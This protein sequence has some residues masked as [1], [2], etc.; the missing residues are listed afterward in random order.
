MVLKGFRS[1]FSHMIHRHF[2]VFFHQGT[3]PRLYPR[4][5]P[6]DLVWNNIISDKMQVPDASL[7]FSPRN[8]PQVSKRG[9]LQSLVSFFVFAC[10][11]KLIVF[12]P[13]VACGICSNT[14]DGRTLGRYDFEGLCS[15]LDV[16]WLGKESTFVA[17]WSI[18][19]LLRRI[20]TTTYFRLAPG[21]ML[22]IHRRCVVWAPADWRT[23]LHGIT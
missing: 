12:S 4:S 22:C 23:D 18:R 7:T 20:Y 13:S 11:V 19:T 15:C 10:S 16:S 9:P 1:L 21:L 17:C 6:D 2:L 8:A 14:L 5:A 3:F